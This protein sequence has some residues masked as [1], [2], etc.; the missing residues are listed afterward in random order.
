MK[1][2]NL[3][4]LSSLFLVIFNCQAQNLPPLPVNLQSTYT[5]GTRTA[6]GAPGKNYWQNSAD[7]TI[8]ISFDPKSRI[9]SGTV[10]IDYVNNSP[11]TLNQIDF[12]LYPNLFK[13]GT[14]RNMPVL[15]EDI[16]D[17]VEIQKLSFN[18]K[19]KMYRN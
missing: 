14:I 12:K 8:K 6:N 3:L 15:P 5:K 1:R 19:R 2:F 13:R 10:G 9:L 7:Y 16:S 4:L 18:K 11:D 17:G